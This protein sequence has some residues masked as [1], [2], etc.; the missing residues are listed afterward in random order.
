[1]TQTRTLLQNWEHKD[2]KFKEL[3]DSGFQLPR[4]SLWGEQIYPVEKFNASGLQAVE[5]GS[6]PPDL[7]IQ[8]DVQSLIPFIN[9]RL[10]ISLNNSDV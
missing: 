7:K 6:N 9:E 8:E 10:N 2:I 1:M 4:Y 5:Y 3:L